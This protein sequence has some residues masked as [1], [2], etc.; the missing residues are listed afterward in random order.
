[1]RKIALHPLV[2]ISVALVLLAAVAFTQVVGATLTGT[3]TDPAGAVVPGAKV[4]IRN[5]ATGIVS[6]VP[7]NEAGFY[8]APNLLPGEY[9]VTVAAT[10]LALNRRT[11]LR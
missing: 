10:G 2:L 3:V 6:V 1:M 11:D 4:T 7:T 8:N 9:E 5:V